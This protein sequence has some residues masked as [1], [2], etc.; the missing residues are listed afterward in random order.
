MLIRLSVSERV[1]IRHFIL[2]CVGIIISL[3]WVDSYVSDIKA[4]MEFRTNIMK[5]VNFTGF[6]NVSGV[7]DSEIIPNYIHYIRLEQPE[8]RFFEAVC[9]KSAFLI[10]RPD[11]IFIHTDTPRLTGKYWTALLNIPGFKDCL[12]IKQVNIPTQVFGV[13]FYWNAHKADV[14]R[15]LVLR[16]Y[17][18]MYLDNDIYVINSLDR[19]RRFEFVLGWPD[20][21]WIGNMLMMGHPDAR[22]L[23]EFLDTYK[24]FR[25]DI[26]YYNGGE[27]PVREILYKRPFLVH[28]EKHRLGVTTNVAWFFY[29]QAGLWDPNIWLHDYDTLHLLIGHRE[30]IDPRYSECRV[31]DEENVRWLD[32]TV[33]MMFRYTWYGSIEPISNGTIIDMDMVNKIWIESQGD[34]HKF[35]HGMYILENSSA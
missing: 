5:K 9:M 27:K 13:E 24:L 17:G 29:V 4:F 25:P 32:M 2:F 15:L 12:V 14:L 31:F 16:K 11:K 22:F 8:I 21:E 26:W 28:N 7:L 34:H 19:Y 33:A 23:T 20:G 1:F 6:D 35:Q 3:T 30:D 10:Q 18:G